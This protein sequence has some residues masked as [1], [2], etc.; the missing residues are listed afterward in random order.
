MT[1]VK[2]RRSTQL[3]KTHAKLRPQHEEVVA[4]SEWWRAE[5]TRYCGCD[6]A[7]LRERLTG[8]LTRKL[9]E[10]RR[11]ALEEL[12][13]AVDAQV[14]QADGFIALLRWRRALE[15]VAVAVRGALDYARIRVEELELAE[16]AA[17]GVLLTDDARNAI[18]ERFVVP[19]MIGPLLN[20]LEKECEIL[21]KDSQPDLG[22]NTARRAGR[23][24]QR[25]VGRQR[26]TLVPIV[27]NHLQSAGYTRA[28]IARLLGRTEKGPT[29][30]SRK[31]D[32]LRNADA[33]RKAVKRQRDRVRVFAPFAERS[34]ALFP[35]KRAAKAKKE[36]E[37]GKA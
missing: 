8:A 32:A 21:F 34:V 5:R 1:D 6:P 12:L 4:P 33:L 23:R 26:D 18:E 36:R 30:A 2:K 3:D 37:T 13:K 15:T 27:A 20:T 11:I 14:T 25:D 29:D 35:E 9:P 22:M 24:S 10:R 7:A 16:A 17:R 28:E 31:A 19:R